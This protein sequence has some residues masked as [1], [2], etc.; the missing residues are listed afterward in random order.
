MPVIKTIKT[1]ICLVLAIGICLLAGYVGSMYSTPSLPTWYAGLQKPDL[2]PPSWVFA[3]VW[4]ALY[5]LMGISLCLILQ[6]GITRGEVLAGLVLF[7]LQLGLNIG[8]SYLF[9]GWHAIFFALMCI[10][11]L[12]SVLLCTI[13]HV[14]RF[15]IIGA[16]LLI[17]YLIWTSFAAYLN[18]A[19]M[20]LNP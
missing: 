15:S 17:P 14:S 1:V 7:V 2:N 13:I 6:S 3:P 9:F 18:Y 19:I 11:A 4:T 20:V 8:W 16:A 5:I 12:W 10:I